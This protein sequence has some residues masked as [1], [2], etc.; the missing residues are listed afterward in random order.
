MKL[1]V[2]FPALIILLIAFSQ[3]QAQSPI[4]E[5]NPTIKLKA[6]VHP[7]FEASLT[8]SVD[9]Q[10]KFSSDPLISNFRIRRLELRSDIKLNDKLS[11]VIRLQFVELKGANPGRVIDLGYFD[12]KLRDAFQIR[13]GQFKIPYEL[14]E[15]TSQEDLRMADRG[16]TSA[17]FVENN[18]ASTQPGIMLFGNLFKETTPFNYYL[19]LVNGSSRAVN[20]DDNSQKNIVGR[21]EYSIIKGV[22]IGAGGQYIALTDETGSSFGADVSIQRNISNKT[23]LILE[24]EYIQGLNINSFIADSVINDVNE[25]TMS[26]YFG[27]ALFKINIEKPWCRTLELG[28]KYETTDPLIQVDDNAYSTVTGNIGFTFLPDNTARLQLNI[29]HTKWQAPISETIDSSNMLVAQFQFKI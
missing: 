3:Q 6:L 9:V 20:Y 18:I 2:C 15:L 17:I 21:L 14:E 12:Y 24:G 25:F 26:G 4:S 7:R 28:G 5:F 29:I 11:G 1:N 8:D 19:A 13:A 22:R 23:V 10:N 27:Q 16:T